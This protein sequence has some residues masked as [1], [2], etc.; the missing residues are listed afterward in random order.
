MAAKETARV[1]DEIQRYQRFLEKPDLF[2]HTALLN[3]Q[4]YYNVQYWRWGKKEATGYLILREDGSVPPRA[5]A[6]P[7]LRLFMSHNNAATNFT[8]DFAVDKEKPV[9]MYQEKRDYLQALLP[10][11]ESMMDEEMR[12]DVAEMIGMC[13]EMVSSVEQ[14]RAIY[15]RGMSYHQQMLA[16]FFVIPEDEILMRNALLESDYILYRRLRRQLDLQEAVDRIYDFF[17]SA[18]RKLPQEEKQIAKKLLDLLRD[19]RRGEIRRIMRQSVQDMELGGAPYRD[20]EEMRQALTACN[21]EI[22]RKQLYPLL[23]NPA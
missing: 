21:E 7:V 3:G 19:Y 17:Q 12:R 5:E 9:W 15:E 18:M 20:E 6:L 11:C 14:L 4:T 8:K 16:R 13:E 22:F 2:N 10:S 23:R 1:R